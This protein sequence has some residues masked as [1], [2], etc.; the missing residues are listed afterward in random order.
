[1]TQK[2]MQFMMVFMAFMSFKV[3]SGL[4]L[5]FI[6]SSIW[7][8]VERSLLSPPGKGNAPAVVVPESEP[9][10]SRSRRPPRTEL[11]TRRKGKRQGKNK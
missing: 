6:A 1:M 2:V 8:I 5:Y 7:G 11:Q 3:A 4:C 10:N 9:G